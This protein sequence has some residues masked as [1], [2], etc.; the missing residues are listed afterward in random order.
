MLSELPALPTDCGLGF[1]ENERLSAVSRD[2]G[3]E[4]PGNA[5]GRLHLWLLD[6]Q[7]IHAEPIPQRQILCLKGCTGSEN[8]QQQSKAW[9]HEFQHGHSGA[10]L[11]KAFDGVDSISK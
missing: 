11:K 2:F 8:R 3:E 5:T 9:S 4:A 1:H 10:A 6:S 7:L